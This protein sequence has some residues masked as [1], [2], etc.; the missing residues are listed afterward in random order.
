MPAL[1][2]ALAVKAYLNVQ[3][4]LVLE[5]WSHFSQN[6]STSFLQACV[7]SFLASGGGEGVG[8][9]Q[10][11]QPL[12][13]GWMRPRFNVALLCQTCQGREMDS[14]CG[15]GGNRQG[16]RGGADSRL[17]AAIN[18]LPHQPD[19]GWQ[20][21]GCWL[22]WR[23]VHSLPEMSFCQPV[24]GQ[25]PSAINPSNHLSINFLCRVK[26]VWDMLHLTLQ[27]LMLQSCGT[28]TAT[29]SKLYLYIYIYIYTLYIL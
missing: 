18:H 24:P 13:T 3:M 21:G 2:S 16:W 17:T 23:F 28:A 25:I 29:V 26:Y 12:L 9:G 22:E 11:G 5:N 8:E 1:Y 15:R 14:Y 10:T 19:A 20:E 27:H 6:I 4:V 7:P